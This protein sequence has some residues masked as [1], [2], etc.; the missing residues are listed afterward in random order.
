MLR[1]SAIFLVETDFWA[2]GAG[3]RD[4]VDKSLDIIQNFKVKPVTFVNDWK[5]AKHLCLRKVPGTIE[6]FLSC[7]Y[8]VGKLQDVFIK[9][10]TT[11]SFLR[12]LGA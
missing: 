11:D 10:R 2:R 12:N 3:R 9:T 5:E 4:E 1:L 7:T 8:E 6:E